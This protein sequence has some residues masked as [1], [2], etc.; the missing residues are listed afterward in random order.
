M[1]KLILIIAFYLNRVKTLY[2]MDKIIYIDI[3]INKFIMG[4][5]II[6]IIF[7]DIKKILSKIKV[8]LKKKKTKT[9]KREVYF[10]FSIFFISIQFYFIITH[11]VNFFNI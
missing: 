9:K 8:F 5:F 4:K 7:Y 6:I 10:S 3:N 1:I 11:V 2:K